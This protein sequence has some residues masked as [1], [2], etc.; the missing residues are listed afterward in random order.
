MQLTSFAIFYIRHQIADAL[1]HNYS[2]LKMK[3]LSD[4]LESYVVYKN[5]SLRNFYK[6]SSE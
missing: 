4:C 5:Y 3:S 1:K 6:S 2:K